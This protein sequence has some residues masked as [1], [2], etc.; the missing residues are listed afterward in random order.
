MSAPGAIGNQVAAKAPGTAAVTL[1]AAGLVLS[2]VLQWLYLTV[3]SHFTLLEPPFTRSSGLVLAMQLFFS[4][5]NVLA[6]VLG[7]GLLRRSERMRRF[8]RL[9][10]LLAL[11]LAGLQVGMQVFTWRFNSNALLATTAL[12][13]AAAYFRFF[14]RP[15]VR[16]QFQARPSSAGRQV[17]A[18]PTEAPRSKAS[19]PFALLACACMEIL[20]A[21]AAA[22]LTAHLWSVFSE[23]SLLDDA[24][25]AEMPPEQE[26]LKLFMFV[27]FALLLSPHLLT[28]VASIGLLLGRATAGMAR[29]YSLV[30]C[31][32]AIGGLLLTACL[33]SK[34]E[35]SFD[36]RNAL[37]LGAFCSFSLVWHLYFVYL[38]ARI[39]ARSD[40]AQ[41]AGETAS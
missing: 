18:G 17:A 20:V 9:V 31:W 28:A 1:L 14:G 21:V 8:S 19:R 24:M 39:R 32:T 40:D 36:V 30:A 10:F 7:V 3:L 12:V 11:G 15:H 26:L 29:R 2:P 13:L 27:V 41:A 35:L 4:P 38:L 16:L 23:D 22:A 6:V 5:G 25:L 34:P 33:M 37:L